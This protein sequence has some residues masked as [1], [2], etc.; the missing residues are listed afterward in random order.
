MAKQKL[1]KL[2]DWQK[3]EQKTKQ[4][5]DIPGL[6][7]DTVDSDLSESNSDSDLQSE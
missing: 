7:S 4:N 3:E 6:E 1:S 2:Q 5:I